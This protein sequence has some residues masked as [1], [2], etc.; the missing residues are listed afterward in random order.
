MAIIKS[1]S[2]D[3][4]I[5]ADGASSSLKLQIDGV[6]KASINSA[7]KFTSTS[8][9]ATVLTGLVTD[10]TVD[11]SSLKSDNAPTND[12]VLTAKSSAAGGLTW[13]AAAS[14]ATGLDDVSGVARAT[15]GLLFNGDTAA[16][17]TLDDYETGTW[18]PSLGVYPSGVTLGTV[19]TANY[20]KIGDRVFIT[21]TCL[22]LSSSSPAPGNDMRITGFPF[23]FADA[24]VAYPATLNYNYK[25]TPQLMMNGSGYFYFQSTTVGGNNQS[26]IGSGLDGSNRLSVVITY[27]T[28]A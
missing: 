10:D 19:D 26:P 6:E 15:S 9:D 11:E 2:T 16:A 12:Y 28:N 4:T 21:L 24:A 14:G 17:N 23:S 18:T 1:D 27:K 7:G 20:T 3:L 5:N 25:E 13:A 8:I 22:I